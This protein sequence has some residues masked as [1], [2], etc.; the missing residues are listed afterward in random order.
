M[1][2]VDSTAVTMNEIDQPPQRGIDRLS[3][4]RLVGVMVGMAASV[5]IGVAVVLWSQDPTFSPLYPDLS[6]NDTV[7]V[8]DALR[9]AGLPFEVD[10]ATGV[11]MVPA[12]KVHEAR[13]QMAALGLPKAASTGF[14]L[15][16]KEQG[17]GTSRFM[18]RAQ[19]QRALEGELARTI[20]SLNAVR[21]ARVHLAVP[22]QSVFVRN[23]KQP[24]ASVLLD[25][26]PGRSL[27]RGQV[28]A[29]IHTVASSVPELESGRVTVVDQKGR[30]L[31]RPDRDSD[32]ELSDTQFEYTQKV[33]SH[34]KQRVEDI[35]APILGADRIHAEVT[36][37]VD[38]TRTEQ[39]REVFNPDMPAVRSEQQ[40][41]EES[42]L[43]IPV[44]IPGALS[45]Q[46]PGAGQ[47]PEVAKGDNGQQNTPLSTSNR[48]TRNY[49]LDKTI[50]HTRMAPGSLRR[51][52]VAVV[53]DNQER[54]KSGGGV[55]R[56]PVSGE[57][58]ER[59]TNLIKQAVG[60]D[61]QRG[62][63]VE[64]INA[65][66]QAA[67]VP[68]P[69]PELPLWQQPWVQDAAKQLLAAL[70]VLILVFAV[71]RPT[72]RALVAREEPVKQEL[73]GE[74]IET[75]EGMMRRMPDGTMV[76]AEEGAEGELVDDEKEKPPIPATSPA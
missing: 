72:L 73:L 36:A 15:L 3:W 44:G 31:S 5:A 43:Q 69:L 14:E 42:R 27:E 47:A 32:M 65:S 8:M 58:L 59:Y 48:S 18:E 49:E 21:N 10:P 25:L 33:E 34:Y 66:F 29:I 30:V 1:A 61:A 40:V 24:S 7:D 53:V 57:D 23:R 67:E 22:K 16:D 12:D 38:F 68:E 74:L 20:V 62:D 41:K 60:F 56:L 51:L 75:K 63:S 71:L 50:S 39:T 45:N 26:Y 17:F 37:D 6:K 46:P 52:S 28:D 9:T 64:V 55:E 70:L 2:T 54:L 19:Y 76:P 4:L 11:L 35:L 13:M